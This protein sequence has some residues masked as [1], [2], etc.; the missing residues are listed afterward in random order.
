M[1]KIQKS[2]VA[3]WWRRKVHSLAPLLNWQRDDRQRGDAQADGRRK[4]APLGLR[5]RCP[6][7]ELLLQL[8]R[9]PLQIC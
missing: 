6:R 9:A 3:Q 2:P 1:K 4:R 5:C 7:A 8:L